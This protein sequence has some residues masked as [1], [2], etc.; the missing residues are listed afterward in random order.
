MKSLSSSRRAL[1]VMAWLALWLLLLTTM[2]RGE[3]PAT[4]PAAEAV[5]RI[6][7]T[8]TDVDRS[9]AFFT[10]VLDFQHVSTREV[11]GPEV[12]EVYGVFGARCR[13]ATLR[14]GSEEV[15]LTQYLASPGRP[16][17]EG[18]RSNDGWFQ[19]IAIVTTDLEAAYRR[20]RHFDVRHASTGPQRLPESI[21][22]A[23]GIGAFYFHDPDGHVLEV[24]QFPAGKGDP[25]W[26]E[27]KGLFV[28]IDHTAIVV[29]DTERSLGFYRDQ[30]GM[31]VAGGSE[32]YG[33][34]QAHLNNVQSAHLRITTLRAVGGGPG[35]EL[36]EYLHPRDGRPYPADAKPND[37]WHWHTV[38]RAT[39]VGD[40]PRLTRDPDGHAVLFVPRE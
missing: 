12:E 16:I 21:P 23:A 26:Q 29:T 5:V 24:I 22:A 8:V 3:P 19:H 34:E 32:N 36:L 14:L 6:G 20:L 30:L 4:Q 10:K 11:T 38:V 31:R 35:V 18:S 37:L 33:R 13:I 2:V 9:V 39:G 7:I 1:A 17:P 40:Q 27:A 15:E 28:G 25:R